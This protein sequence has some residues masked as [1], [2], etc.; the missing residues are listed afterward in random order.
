MASGW[1]RR[2]KTPAV[3]PRLPR[4]TRPVA[5]RVQTRRQ[6]PSCAYLQLRDVEHAPSGKA[7][8]MDGDDADA[9]VGCVLGHQL[10]NPTSTF[11]IEPG[12]GLI[13]Q[14]DRPRVDQK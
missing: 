9:A 6:D 11:S 10:F 8:A 3:E 12:H 7:L 4:L 1:R 5:V 2:Q 13:Q 14:P